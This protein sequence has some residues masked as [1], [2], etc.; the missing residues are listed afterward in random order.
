M[1]VASALR[2][3][4]I[5]MDLGYYPYV[6]HLTRFWHMLHPKPYLTWLKLDAVFLAVCDV[7]IRLP[8]ASPGADMEVEKAHSL[9]I[10]VYYGTE[11]FIKEF[12]R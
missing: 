12:K 7:L 6:P 9:G 11:S 2:A 5:L 3:A 1:N 10:P 8:G 4:N